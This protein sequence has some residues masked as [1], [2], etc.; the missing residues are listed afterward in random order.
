[1][2][3]TVVSCHT[4]KSGCIATPARFDNNYYKSMCT[5]KPHCNRA[6]YES[7]LTITHSCVT[8]LI[9]DNSLVSSMCFM[10]AARV[11]SPDFFKL[12]HSRSAVTSL[13]DAQQASDL[14]WQPSLCGLS[15]DQAL[16]I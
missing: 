13:Q 5:C 10:F 8:L 3:T 12:W 9:V 7:I 14:S 6:L 16:G 4:I 11:L 2:S 15:A 1:M